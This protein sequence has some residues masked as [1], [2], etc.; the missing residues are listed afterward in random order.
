MNIGI[1]GACGKM[2]K[3]I[4]RQLFRDPEIKKISAFERGDSPDIGKDM[5]DILG[6]TERRGTPVLGDLRGIHGTVDCLIDF[7]FPGP[8]LEHLSVCV[9][10]RIPMVIC[11]TGFSKDEEKRI[12]DAAKVIPIV[13]SPNMAIGMNLVFKIVKEVAKVLGKDFEI[14]VDETHHIHKKDSPSGTAKMIA[15]KIE[16]SAGRSVP[17]E[18][19]REGEVV[20]NHGII[21]DG[22]Y[23]NIE[24]RHD[25][26]SRDVF[27]KGAIKAAKFV[28]GKTPGLYTMADVLGL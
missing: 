15:K 28:I 9:K 8:T 23:E 20:G 2:G 22:E 19:K 6:N 4:T 3:M 13:F 26:K 12:E 10:E 25:A 7:T 18:A 16:E 24:I 1:A 27:A 11:A 17:I 5:A 21:F 14:T